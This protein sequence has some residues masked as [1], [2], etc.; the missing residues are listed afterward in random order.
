MITKKKVL[1]F[2]IVF[3]LVVFILITGLSAIV[4]YLGGN[5]NQS[6]TG[7]DTLVTSWT[8]VVITSG[9]DLSGTTN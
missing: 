2:I 6:M 4:P 5:K 1:K 9:T 3:I 8:D 7:E